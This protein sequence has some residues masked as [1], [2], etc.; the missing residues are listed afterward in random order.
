MTGPAS[1]DRW[2]VGFMLRPTVDLHAPAV[3]VVD[4]VEGRKFKW[5]PDSLSAFVLA[6]DGDNGD[7]GTVLS[8]DAAAWYDA[9]GST[10]RRQHLV[11][12]WKHWQERGW[13]PSDRFYVAS[14]R[15][16][17]VDSDDI[18]GSVRRSTIQRLIDSD[19]LP[20]APLTL[21]S[22]VVNLPTPRR[23]GPH[24][25]AQ[26]LVRRRTVRAFSTKPVSGEVLSGLLWFGLSDV[27]RCRERTT[28]SEPA[29]Y[30]SESYGSALDLWVC[31]FSV[32][33]LDPGVYR[34]EMSHSMA[35]VRPGDHRERATSILQGMSS[36]QSA[37]WMLVLVADMPRYQWRYRHEHA[38]R[39]LYIEC[40][41]LGQDLI[42]LGT[43]YG[44]GTL[45]TPAQKDTELL[46]LLG[47]PPDRY[48]PLY[49]LTMGF[50][51]RYSDLAEPSA[52]GE[53]FGADEA[54]D[55]NE[56]TVDDPLD[57]AHPGLESQSSTLGSD[58]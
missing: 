28:V 24:D 14:R 8:G 36:P 40:G 57:A 51:H 39:R 26:L 4:A 37:A 49:T 32:S 10:S 35:G 44:L 46:D 2:P 15:W 23:P 17:Y 38:L 3:E 27:R 1:H 54:L 43:S 56:S 58:P 47:L 52:A 55:V 21:D 48:A 7:N 25:L 5:Q 30:L 16:E 34:Y 13:H 18:D 33:G 50:S 53:S 42:V 11:E 12:G 41:I 31:V 6:D 9:L 22:P 19:E 20:P 29:S 45:V